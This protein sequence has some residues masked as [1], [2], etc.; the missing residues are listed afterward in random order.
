MQEALKDILYIP[1]NANISMTKEFLINMNF[2]TELIKIQCFSNYLR[3]FN[4]V[5]FFQNF[6][7]ILNNYSLK[8]INNNVY[9]FKSNYEKM[10]YDIMKYINENNN[11]KNRIKDLYL[12]ITKI[13]DKLYE[14]NNNFQ[15]KL[16][17]LIMLYEIK[18]KQ[19]KEKIKN[20][21]NNKNIIIYNNKDYNNI[22]NYNN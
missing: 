5:K 19:I 20:E 21:N 7:N 12:Y 22:I 1:S 4:Y 17:Y 14:V 9:L 15:M 6:S 18:I 10:K 3:E 16:N 8:E 2:K 13:K 11:L